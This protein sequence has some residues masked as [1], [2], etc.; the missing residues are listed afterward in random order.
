MNLKGINLQKQ[1]IQPIYA[2]S[3]HGVAL[4]P[5]G[6]LHATL[7][8]FPRECFNDLRFFFSFIIIVT[9]YIKQKTL[10]MHYTYN[11]FISQA[12]LLYAF[13]SMCISE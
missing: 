5:M 9:C 8:S 2:S 3:S 12:L 13:M 11:T 7:L 4:R 10:N 1:A 6:L